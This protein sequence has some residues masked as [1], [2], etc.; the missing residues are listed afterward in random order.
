M[1]WIVATELFLI[2]SFFYFESLSVEYSETLMIVM[3]QRRR[4]MTVS[5]YSIM[6]KITNMFPRVS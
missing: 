2:L 5:P 3:R 1:W 6:S 4:V